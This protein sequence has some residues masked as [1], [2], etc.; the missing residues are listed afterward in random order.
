M[1][2]VTL[3]GWSR[4]SRSARWSSWLC[5]RWSGTWLNVWATRKSWVSRF[6]QAGRRRD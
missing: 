4:A 5:N 1:A 6:W 2:P 3:L